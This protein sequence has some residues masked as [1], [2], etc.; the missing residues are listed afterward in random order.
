MNRLSS[1]EYTRRADRALAAAA[2]AATSAERNA[3][4]DRA[5][6]YAHKSE[7]GHRP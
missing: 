4:L 3:D 7:L 6:V 2:P 1:D 5:A